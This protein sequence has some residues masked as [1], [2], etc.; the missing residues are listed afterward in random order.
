[1]KVD[2]RDKILIWVVAVLAV[3]LV[4]YSSDQMKHVK[5]KEKVAYDKGWNDCKHLV[6]EL[7]CEQQDSL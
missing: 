3:S 6:K 2:N 1:M 7:V 5:A 4:L